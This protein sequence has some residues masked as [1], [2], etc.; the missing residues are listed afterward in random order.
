MLSLAGFIPEVS[1]FSGDAATSVLPSHP[2]CCPRNFEAH[3]A[4]VLNFALFC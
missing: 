3:R 4:L 1:R 2:L